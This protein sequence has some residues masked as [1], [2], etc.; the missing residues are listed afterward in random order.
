M[1]TS[2]EFKAPYIPAREK[3]IERVWQFLLNYSGST[4][5]DVMTGLN[6]DFQDAYQALEALRGRESIYSELIGDGIEVFKLQEQ[7]EEN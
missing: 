3:M 5:C 4:I 1:K 7:Q 6:I 2:K